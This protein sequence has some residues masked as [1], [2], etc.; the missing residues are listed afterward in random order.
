LGWKIIIIKR[1]ADKEVLSTA[2][3]LA[4]T[5]CS[6]SPDSVRATKAALEDFRRGCGGVEKSFLRSNAI[7]VTVA[8]YDGPNFNEGLAAF[9]EKRQPRWRDPVRLAN[10][11]SRRAKL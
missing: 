3:S 7:Q 10:P 11:P 2:L 9:N 8:V 5:I 1:A 4:Q 6:G